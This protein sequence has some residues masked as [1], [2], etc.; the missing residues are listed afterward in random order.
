MT[1]TI[2]NTVI[3][4]LKIIKQG[5]HSIFGESDFIK[6]LSWSEQNHIPLRIK[7]GVDPTAPDLH[8][9]HTVVL[10][11]LRQFQDMGHTVIFLIG[12]FTAQIGDPSGRNTTRPPLTKEQ[13]ETNALTY[14]SQVRR[15]LDPE[16]TEVQHNST[17]FDKIGAGGMLELASKYTVAQ[18]IERDDFDKRFK[19]NTPINI[20]EFIYPLMQG[21]DSVALR[22]D[23]EIGGTDQTFN[24]LV[25]RDLQKAY[26]QE[27]QCILTMP[28]LIGLDG[29]EKM[30]K[31]KGNYISITDDPLSMYGKLMS[32]S[33]SL[34]WHYFSRVSTLTHQEQSDLQLEVIS[35][36]TSQRDAKVE[37]AINVTTIYHGK[38]AAEDAYQNFMRRANG[39]IPDN[40]PEIAISGAP[41][42]ITH[43]LKQTGLCSSISDAG[44][45]IEQNAV[46]MN[47][48]LV[49]EK[50]LLIY[51]S[52]VV[53]QI[54]KRKFMRVT[55]S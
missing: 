22:C 43:L 51:P 48:V 21:Y 10:N 26:N 33:D 41:I 31:S 16:K 25:G 38:A 23:V 3:E 13:I 54:G 28:L 15:I 14:F 36:M 27:P 20:N 42:G 44:R 1:N 4:N 47:Q 55:I 40:I 39:D 7:L 37:L 9:G 30:S 52:T 17:W 11:K 32:I 12:D 45:M 50:T 34:M 46:K 8:L 5:T 6:K 35:G 53:L 29:V 18:M 24:L 2:S 49:S 19:S